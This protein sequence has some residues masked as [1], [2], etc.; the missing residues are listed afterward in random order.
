TQVS[1]SLRSGRIAIAPFTADE[2]PTTLPSW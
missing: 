1:K 2:P